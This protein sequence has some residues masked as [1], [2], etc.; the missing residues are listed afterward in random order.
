M[1]RHL[2]LEGA[3][4]FRDLDGY[5]TAS[6]GSV[7]WGVLFRTASLSDVTPGDIATL[8]KLGLE[9]VFDLRTQTE[10]DGLGVAPL[11]EHGVS[12]RH[13][14]V[15][16]RIEPGL[17]PVKASIWE[18]TPEHYATQYLWLLEQGREAFGTVVRALAEERPAAT[19]YHCTGGRDRAGLMT[20]VILRA[21]GVSDEVISADYALTDR[22][23]RF[24]D[25]Q[26][27]RYAKAFKTEPRKHGRLSTPAKNMAHA[28][29]AMDGR[30]ASIDA[31]L[32]ECEVS[33][34]V[35]RGLREH[36][37]EPDP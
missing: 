19:A 9:V 6:G 20:A 22:Y 7:R 8:R 36:L 33:E 1:E 5:A 29:R 4:N 35:R 26:S 13:T 24:D 14:P 18:W 28:L 10:R 17:S 23:L 12:V 16:E 34:A 32:E 2:P 21:L 27:E 30:W 11:A 25:R 3:Q 15:V 37:L 31:Y